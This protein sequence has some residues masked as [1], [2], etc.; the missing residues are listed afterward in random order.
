[1]EIHGFAKD[2]TFKLEK[3][4]DSAAWFRF[5]SSEKTL[6]WYPF[7]FELN[8]GYT[9]SGKRLKVIWIVKNTG[10][11]EMPF[12]IGGHPGFNYPRYSNTEECHAYLS[13]DQLND[14]LTYIV[15]DGSGFLTPLL[16]KHVV[17]VDEAGLLPVKHELFKDD[18]LIFENSQARKVT[19][20]N[21]NK[22]KY[23]SVEFDMPVFA[24][25]SPGKKNAPFICIEPWWGRGDRTNEIRD[26]RE[27][28]WTQ[29][30]SP[31]ESFMSSYQIEIF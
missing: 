18:A 26:M 31:G 14:E 5:T 21:Q 24:L 29:H 12:Q 8:I 22:R 10:H 27:R 16:E 11:A 19:I 2:C 28:D 13:F 7:P 15:K 6:Q 25:W 1:M 20:Y 4:E 30:V 9:L 3:E 23:L 17:P